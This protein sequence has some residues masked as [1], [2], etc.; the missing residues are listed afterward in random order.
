VDE[1]DSELR[2]LDREIAKF[3]L[4]AFQ[5]EAPE[6]L[7]AQLA[8]ALGDG[9]TPLNRSLESIGAGLAEARGEI[10]RGVQAGAGHAAAIQSDLGARARNDHEQAERRTFELQQ[11]IERLAREVSLARRDIR[12]GVEAT[13]AATPSLF[14]DPSVPPDAFDEGAPQA[15]WW[16]RNGS[17]LAG[18]GAALVIAGGLGAAILWPR[19]PAGLESAPAPAPREAPAIAGT[20][21]PALSGSLEAAQDGF[22]RVV[23]QV[24][25]SWSGERRRVALEALC[26]PGGASAPCPT[27]QDRWRTRGGSP[28][29]V[30]AALSA[31]L[32][33]LSET[34]G[35]LA[36]GDG[37]R[38]QEP[39][40]GAD[41]EA[42]LDCLF[43]EAGRAKSP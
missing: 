14:E 16:R 3:V 4:E 25:S 10:A 12:A 34:D 18:G 13:S 24:S 35:C 22:A 21:A 33:A 27:F 19:G 32:A 23:A 29:E 41:P 38:R 28:T 5:R 11:A 30:Q 26:G 31:T 17:W 7:R 6:A 39:V 37:A 8:A 40:A 9:L 2:M 15:A 20:D 36:P 42:T 43:T 1:L